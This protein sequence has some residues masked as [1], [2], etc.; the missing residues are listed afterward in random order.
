MDDYKMTNLFGL[1]KTAIQKIVKE[2]DWPDYRAGQ[3]FTWI[4]KGIESFDDMSNLPLNMREKL[5][6]EYRIYHLRIIKKIKEK[7]TD[8]IKYLLRTEDDLQIE[9]VLMRYRHGASVCISTQAGCNMAC[10]FCASAQGG[11]IRNLTAGEMLSQ[12]YAIQKDSGNR[13]D[14]VVLMGS[15]EPLEN[16]DNTIAFL[17]LITDKDTLNISRRS[18]TL[19][20]CGIADKIYALAHADTG[21]NLSVSLHNAIQEQRQTLMPVARRYG[22]EELINACSYYAKKTKRRVTFEYALIEGKNDSPHHARELIK[23]IKGINCL[24]NLIPVNEARGKDIKKSS[25]DDIKRFYD[26]LTK[27]NI[28]TTIRRTLGSSINAACGQLRAGIYME[29]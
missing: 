29:D 22:M 27:N 9:A 12:I 14:N 25:E 16:Y 26:I 10:S 23:K 18:I 2:N 11:L 19:S 17:N 13:A 15:G 1:D 7:N 3:I 6:S 28:N 24:V 21:V 4:Y 8:T 20:T 5:K